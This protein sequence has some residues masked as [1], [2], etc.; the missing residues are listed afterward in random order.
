LPTENVAYLDDLSRDVYCVFGVPID[1][2]DL[3]QV[4]YRIKASAAS[5]S[6]FLIS[7][8]NVNFLVAS[9]IDRDFKMSL[10]LS[11]LCVADGVP[12][13]LLSRL[14][15][16]ALKGR[17]AGSDLF[18]ELKISN[19]SVPPLNVFFFGGADGVA[20]RASAAL[21]A[22][23][24]GLKCLGWINPG[25][26]SVEEMSSDKLIEDVNSSCA[27]FLVV[28]LGA[29][30]GQHWL[31]RNHQRLRIP[32]RAHFGAAL[33][34]EAGTI[35][36]APYI[37]QKYGLEWLWRIVEEPH[38]WRR[39]WVDG[40]LLVRLLFTHVLP[41]AVMAR[42]SRLSGHC[43]EFV[44]TQILDNEFVTLRLSGSAT[45]PFVIKAAPA[46]RSAVLCNKDV[47]IE[48]GQVP[49]IDSRFFG[50]LLMLRKQLEATGNN[51]KFS[52]LTPRLAR[53]FRLNG[54]EL[55]LTDA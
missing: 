40:Y 51:L 10:L 9:Q 24:G 28:A 48:L 17:L 53:L 19:R 15:G 13:V 43:Q 26:G 6:T 36:R 8:V 46:F 49:F 27:D 35:R 31:L 20:A 37:L 11:D 7:T 42:W 4:L 16:A 55:L 38:L 52:G 50:L 5:R 30:K 12:I 34:F 54:V 3:Q 41:L 39:Y 32:V 21:N 14:N 23:P 2:I 29:K 33:N 47:V 44:V 1:A 25:F 45:K 22:E 18:K